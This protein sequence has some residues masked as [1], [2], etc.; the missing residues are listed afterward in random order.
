MIRYLHTLILALAAIT[1]I[2]AGL[3]IHNQRLIIEILIFENTILR[4]QFLQEP[5]PEKDV[6]DLFVNI[7]DEYKG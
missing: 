3:K 2:T 6:E 7:S 4:Q 5:Q 1:L